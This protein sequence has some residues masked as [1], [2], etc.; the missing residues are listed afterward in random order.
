MAVTDPYMPDTPALL[1]AGTLTHTAT[2]TATTVG[3]IV[4]SLP[5]IDATLT[6]DEGMAPRVTLDLTAHLTTDP[7]ADRLDPR[8]LT[9]V[10]LSAG[11]DR[12][13]GL[14]DIQPIV[15]LCLRTITRSRPDDTLNITAA[16]DESLMLDGAP[17]D[18]FTL[19]AATT[20]DAIAATIRQVLPGAAITTNVASPGPSVAITNQP[21]VDR[22]SQVLDFA[23]SMATGVD[24]YDNGFRQW[25]IV[26]RPNVISDTPTL[27]LKDGPGGTLLSVSDALDRNADWFNRVQ[28][29]YEW[30]D[31]SDVDHRVV[32]TGVAGGTFGPAAGNTRTL[33]LSRD[34]PT[35]QTAANTA[36]ATIANRTTTRGRELTVEA[37]SAYWVRPGDT[38]TVTETARGT[39]MQWHLI[40]T[41]SFDLRS[42]LMTIT[43]RTPEVG[44]TPGYRWMDVPYTLLWD[45]VDSNVVWDTLPSQ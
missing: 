44:A 10:K 12:P 21:D 6:F 30:T 14:D 24:V 7:N 19:A 40:K 31:G 34:L 5:I 4:V 27:A 32:G 3:G 39:G 41:V 2:A 8:L 11:Y 22:W 37:P 1:A 16:S 42:G 35:T 38:I 15:D 45:D 36:A 17:D 29:I 25:L 33:T 18:M 28:V 26:D 13:D 43:T 20:A 9:R 23:D